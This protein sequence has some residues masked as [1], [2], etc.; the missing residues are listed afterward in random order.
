MSPAA[1]WRTLQN[2][3]G[4]H[5]ALI[6]AAS[7]DLKRSG[8]AWMLSKMRVQINRHLRLGESFE[9]ETW[10]S[11][12]LKGARAYRDFVLKDDQGRICASARSIWV[13]VDLA[14]RRPVRVPEAILNLCHDS[15]YEIPVVNEAWL[16]SPG[17]GSAEHR[18]R[19][20]WS[21]A[22]Q[23]EHVNNVTMMRWA[24]DCLP[25]DF[26][27]E[28]ELVGAEVHYRAEASIGDEVLV[29]TEMQGLNLKQEILKDEITVAL[30]HSG[31]RRSDTATVA[32]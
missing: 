8:Q 13:I 16:G 28:H 15:D 11:T 12:R 5:A 23:N 29:R 26:L 20:Y 17:E 14:S 2:A 10:P 9:V 1:Y 32:P 6:S 7:E 19:A 21:D 3:A 24:V 18:Y 4:S 27:E 31:W 22:D 30:V 25:L